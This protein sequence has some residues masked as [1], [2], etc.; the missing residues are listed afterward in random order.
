VTAISLYALILC[1]SASRDSLLFLCLSASRDSLLILCL[2][3]W[4]ASGLGQVLDVLAVVL[5]RGRSRR[6]GGLCRLT[7]F[8]HGDGSSLLSRSKGNEG[9]VEDKEN[10]GV[11]C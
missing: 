5:G 6:G 10:T 8:L 9:G 3:A 1:L 2:S 11:L 4:N 7:A